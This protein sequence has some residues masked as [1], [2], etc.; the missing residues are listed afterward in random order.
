MRLDADEFGNLRVHLR[1]GS[2]AKS[3]L[4]FSG[5]MDHPGFEAEAMT[6]RGRLQARWRGSVQ[7]EYFA[8]AKVRF[9]SDGTWVRG[10]VKSVKIGKDVRG[11]R[12]VQSVVVAVARD[13]ASGSVGMWDFPDPT[14]KGTRLYARG[15]DDVGGVAAIMAALDVLAARRTPVD[16]YATFTRAEEVGFAGAIAGA[17]NGLIPRNARIVAVETS[18]EI[19][20]VTMGGGPILRVGDRDAIFTPS[21]TAFCHH[22]AEDLAK[23]DKT[24][25]HQ[26]KLMDAGTCESA[27]FCEFGYQATGLC[28]ALGNYHNMD[29]TRRRVGPEYIDL[30]DWDALVK[31]FVALATSRREYQANVNPAFRKALDKLDRAYTPL[32][33]K[34]AARTACAK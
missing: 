34:T 24:F 7:P 22:V 9:Y 19:P 25:K 32:L 3:P 14:I 28:V 18:S 21:L 6:G 10:T 8:G 13:V 29:R 30:S 2:A 31:W 5:H 11:R 27:A 17:H 33:R 4:V 15:C 26:R 16:V 12:R 1:R 20:G 23:Q